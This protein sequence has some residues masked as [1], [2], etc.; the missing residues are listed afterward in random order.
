MTTMNDLVR[1]L[2]AMIDWS[3]Y[4]APVLLVECARTGE[5]EW[6]RIPEDMVELLDEMRERMDEEELP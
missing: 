5:D 3:D 2:L 4:S 6:V 1:K